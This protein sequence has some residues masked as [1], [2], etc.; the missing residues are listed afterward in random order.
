MANLLQSSQCVTATTPGY[1]TDYLTNLAVK[2]N[3][4]QKAAS[5]VCAQPLQTEAFCKAGQ[6]YGTQQPAINTALGEVGSAAGTNISGAATPYINASVNASPLCA[7]RPLI[8]S[9]TKLN[10]GQLAACY[11][12]PYING[13]VQNM[14]NVAQGNIMRNLGPGATA[15]GVGS[16]QFGSTRGAA[17]LGQINAQAQQQLNCQ[18]GQT[19][20]TGYGQALSAA[21]AKQSALDQLANTTVCA[22]KAQNQAQ[23]L[24]GQTELCAA[25]SAAANLLTA[26]Q[27]TAQIEC[28]NQKTNLANLNAMATL[29]GQCQTIKQNKQLFPLSTLATEAGL[30]SGYSIPAST[31]TELNMSPLSALSATGSGLMGLLQC[32]LDAKGNPIPGSAAINGIV[33]T[34]KGLLPSTTNPNSSP[35]TTNPNSS[36]PLA[37]GVLPTSDG[38]YEDASGHRVNPDGTPY[39]S[40]GTN[41]TTGLGSN[42][43]SNA[44]TTPI[45]YGPN[46]GDLPSN[47]YCP[48]WQCPV[49]CPPFAR[50]GTVKY[51]GCSSAKHRGALPYRKG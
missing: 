13:A 4:A 25:K 37:P 40:L 16:G 11:M 23:L 47:G 17:V 10:L 38:E 27:N 1:Y 49:T 2:G 50:G 24:A 42:G 21:Q 18:I 6:I 8:C 44:Y 32:K 48:T 51:N 5:F 35:S 34:I 29:G 33:N 36:P 19:L 15:A 43:I 7:A 9:A 12:S 3:E 46:Y 20:N 22:Q 30:L 41:D 45:N 14:S 28:V 31:K 39:D 26:G